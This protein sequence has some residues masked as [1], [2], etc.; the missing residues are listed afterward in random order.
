MKIGESVNLHYSLSSN[1][2]VMFGQ[3]YREDISDASFKSALQGRYHT[4]KYF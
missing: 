1:F 2:T 3:L 4:I